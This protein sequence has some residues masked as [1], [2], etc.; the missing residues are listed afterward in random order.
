MP[1]SFSFLSYYPWPKEESQA[2]TYDKDYSQTTEIEELVKV[3]QAGDSAAFSNLYEKFFDSIYRYTNFRTGNVAEA[4]D[5]TDGVFLR[6]LE[7]RSSF[8][9]KGV[10]FS[11]WLFRIAHNLLVDYHRKQAKRPTVPMEQAEGASSLDLP[12]Q[13]ELGDV[14]QRIPPAR[15]SAME[16][17]LTDAYRDFQATLI[18]LGEDIP[19][20][21]LR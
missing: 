12:H 3:V 15:R 10:L 9:W 1:G 18:A 2:V 20:P 19:G 11:S 8:K 7:A 14:L 21:Q 5:M 17:L 13:A 4:E 6:A 16:R